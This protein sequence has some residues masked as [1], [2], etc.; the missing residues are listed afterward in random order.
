[1]ALNDRTRPSKTLTQ[2]PIWMSTDLRDGN[3]SLFELMDSANQVA[4]LQDAG[5]WLQGNRGC[6][7][8][9]SQTDFDFVRQL[10]EE[11]WHSDD[12]TI[13]VITQAREDLI[14]RS[15]EALRGAPKAI[16][17]LYNATAP[18]WRDVVFGLSQAFE[19]K[20]FGR[21]PLPG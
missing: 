20:R 8:S 3:Q 12:V 18:A 10:I 9:A 15:F 14:R 6:L 16:V 17:H 4:L 13:E 1:M 5:Y 11:G 2:A 21:A 19:V 7:P